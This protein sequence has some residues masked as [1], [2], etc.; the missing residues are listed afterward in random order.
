MTTASRF[1]SRAGWVAIG[2]ALSGALGFGG[3]QIARADVTTGDRSVFVAVTPARILD[4]RSN[5]GLPG[6]FTDATPR[7]LQVTGS[8]AIAPSGSSVIVPPTATAVVANVTVVNP[9]SAGFLSVRPGDASGTP[10]TSSL[11][12]QSQQN[13][14]NSVTV[15]L[16]ADGRIQIWLD[17]A[18]NAGTADVLVDVVGYYDDHDHDDRYLTQ[19]GS[20]AGDDLQDLD[21]TRR[22]IRRLSEGTGVLVT[23]APRRLLLQGF[24]V[25]SNR[26]GPPQFST[27]DCQLEVSTDAS[28]FTAVGTSVLTLIDYDNNPVPLTATVDVPQGAHDVR[29]TCAS[30]FITAASRPRADRSSLT[31]VTTSE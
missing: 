31:V 28:P 2:I 20:S 29:I 3:L 25:L 6:K 17:T 7:A 14:P 8:V 30:E 24:V 4:S 16:P 27:V 19:S 13:V 15:S 23:T 26:A 1:S 10:T 5:V 21:A 9:T 11:N 12:F 18:Q 22:E